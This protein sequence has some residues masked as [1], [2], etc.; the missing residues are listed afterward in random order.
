LAVTTT[1]TTVAIWAA[2]TPGH[3]AY[4]TAFTT[5]YPTSTLPARMQALTGSSCNVCHTPG[6]T[7]ALGSCYKDD[8]AGQLGAG[9]SIMD[10]LTAVAMLDS[11]GDGVPNE[12]EILMPRTDQPGQIGYHPGLKGP[13]GTGP[14]NADPN[15]PVTN[16]PETPAAA[17]YANCDNSTAPPILNAND[18]QCFLNKF[19]AADPYA[20]CDNS[21]APPILN[22][23]DFQCF[24]NKFAIGCT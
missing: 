9:L 24:L 16:Q 18:F 23:N 22:A 1:V 14:C 3:P 19:A 12:V 15:A 8:I 21:T 17:C 7:S 11:D 13:T 10:A 6:N 5:K 20:N 4:L 2:Q